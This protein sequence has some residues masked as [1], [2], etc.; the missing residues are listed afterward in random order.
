MPAPTA[1]VTTHQSAELTAY[2][3]RLNRGVIPG[4]DGIRALAV[5]LV[6]ANHFGF[7]W[8]NG[9]LGVLIFF[10]LSGFLI[11]WLMLKELDKTGTVSLKNFYRRRMLR[12]FPAF[13]AFWLVGVGIYLVRGHYL[14]WGQAISAFF[15]VS[16]YWMGLVPSSCMLFPHTWS[17]SIEEQFYL[18]WPALF[19]LG[20]RQPRRLPLFLGI[21]IAAVWVHRGVL[22]AC[23]VPQEYLYRA[24]DTRLD[25]LAIGCLTAILL[26]RRA[27]DGI[28]RAV[29]RSAWLPLLTL[30]LLFGAQAGHDSPAFIFTVGYALEPLL[31]AVFLLQLICFSETGAWRVFEHPV[32][33]YLGRISYPMYLWQQLTLFTAKRVAIDFPPAL[34]FGFA[35]AVTVAFASASYFLVEKPFLRMKSRY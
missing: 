23:G 35:L 22:F 11:T 9:A 5:L 18:L 29:T 27:M 15:Y 24:F 12:I 25:H 34:Q 31:T 2:Y 30:A 7:E 16:N 21:A 1:S 10:V 26:R 14:D 13:Y 8:I 20:L 3:A 4:L 19:L 17:L 28:V 6:I 33:R 32:A